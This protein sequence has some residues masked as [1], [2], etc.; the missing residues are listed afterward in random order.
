MKG[1]LFRGV[2][3]LSVTFLC[4]TAL[5]ASTFDSIKKRGFLKCGVTTGLAGFGELGQDGT[6][7][8]FDVDFCRAVAV[9]TLGDKDKVKFTP[10]TA[11]ERFTALQSGEVDVLA[12]NTTW[13]F[14]RDADLGLSFAGVNYYDGQ[15]FLV[16]KN[17]GVFSAKELDGATICVKA[18]TTTELNLADFFTTYG[19]KFKPVVFEKAEEETAAFESGRCDVLTTDQSQL[20]SMRARM[21]KADDTVVLPEVISKEPLGP[22]VRQGDDQWF[23]VVRW[24]L[25]ALVNA[26]ELG[27]NSKNVDAELKNKDPQVKRLLGVDPM[28]ASKK[29]GLKDDWAYQ[30]V[31][32]VG[33]YGEVFERNIG[34]NTPLKIKRGLNALWSDGGLQ[35][36]PPMR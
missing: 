35:Y 14:T 18:G 32:Q 5:H 31:K 6:W 19:M 24:T 11:K 9:A 29:L 25:A 3:A 15:G 34:V 17:T 7:T 10:L 26:E 20:Y 36:A 23:K 13:T 22:V 4:N 27:V 28:S 1:N 12:R 33:N 16:N 8:G 21:K 30:V 2:V